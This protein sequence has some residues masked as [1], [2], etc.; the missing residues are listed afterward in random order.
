ML[1]FYFKW[2]PMKC[3]NCRNTKRFSLCC[4][5]KISSKAWTGIAKKVTVKD[6]LQQM[7]SAIQQGNLALAERISQTL[8]EKCVG[9]NQLYYLSG[10]IYWQ[11]GNITKAYSLVKLAYEH[12]YYVQQV[13]VNLAKLSSLSGHH[14]QALKL[15]KSFIDSTSTQVMLLQ[16]AF[17]IAKAAEDSQAALYYVGLLVK[18]A[19]EDKQHWQDCIALFDECGDPRSGIKTSINALKSFPDEPR[20]YFNL[21]S[22]SERIN[23]IEA[24]TNAVRKGLTLAPNDVFGV[25]IKSRL[26]RRQEK[27]TEAQVL[28][29][30]CDNANLDKEM[31]RLY[32]AECVLNHR[33]RKQSRLALS[34]ADKMHATS[35]HSEYERTLASVIS[36]YQSIERFNADTLSQ[37]SSVQTDLSPLFIIG[38]P[39]CGSTLVEKLIFECYQ[40]IQTDE[41]IA[42]EEVEK[43]I[44]E[45]LAHPWWDTKQSALIE[46][47]AQSLFVRLASVYYSTQKNEGFTPT[48]PQPLIDKNLTNLTRLPLVSGFFPN[49]PIVKL[50]RHPLDT[51]VSCYLS[52]FSDQHLW[53]KNL[54]SVAEHFVRQ[55]H[56]W[57]SIKH[58]LTNP[59]L[60]L[61]YE[62]VVAY[63]GLTESAHHFIGQHWKGTNRRRENEKT[64]SFQTQTASYSQVEKPVNQRSILFS[65]EYIEHIPQNVIDVLQPF[66]EQWQICR[67]NQG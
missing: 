6:S 24:S 14:K 18:H 49:A 19:P 42:F 44:Y 38:F 65:D 10:L 1:P 41:C 29:D 33:A 55:E 57:Q 12:D 15:V 35:R 32:Y 17:D 48:R 67:E 58:T 30:K 23:D 3:E 2:L 47:L 5:R 50:I 34:C 63:S 39:R 52:N 27:F 60:E 46:P 13:K 21:A 64:A 45:E 43:H 4:G 26:L 16:V 62:N 9:N 8:Q 31:R 56:H 22:L 25:I 40:S 61:V 54:L 37:L 7:Q 36:Y 66:I 51:V 28:L 59:V 11:R 53:Q 20:F